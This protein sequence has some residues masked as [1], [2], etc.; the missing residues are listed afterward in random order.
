[1][2][3]GVLSL[4][5]FHR[6]VFP[7]VVSLSVLAPAAARADAADEVLSFF[8]KAAKA[9]K[10]QVVALPGQLG[11]RLVDSKSQAVAETAPIAPATVIGAETPAFAAQPDLSQIQTPVVTAALV[12]LPEPSV[13]KP[14]HRLYCAEYVR[15]QKGLPVFGDAKYWWDKARDLYDR[16]AQPVSDSVMVFATS[17]RLKRGHVAMV[18]D[19]V[20]PREIRVDQANW[21]NHGEIDHS[22]PVLDVGPANDW[23]LVRVWD[24]R[25]RQFGAHVY[26]ISGFIAKGLTTATRD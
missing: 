22:T 8:G 13:E 17:L 7:L 1:M 10:S 24:T 18:T 2:V 3:V 16:V 9:V 26:A 6:A 21:Q 23:S 19:I 5:S 20:S 25:S 15:R 4:S 11:I 12:A 14:A